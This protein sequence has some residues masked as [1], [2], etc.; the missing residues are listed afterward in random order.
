MPRSLSVLLS[1]VLLLSA[2][3]LPTPSLA[4]TAQTA[5]SAASAEEPVIVTAT[6]VAE[7][8]DAALEPVT[9][10]GTAE[11]ER[12]M[13]GDVGELLGTVIGADVARSGGPG[14]PSSLFLR[15]ANSNQTSVMIDGVRINP[16]TIGGAN[17]AD[18][19]PAAFERIE[20]VEG[21][22]S[23][24]YGS[25]AIG[26]VV[27]LITRHGGPSRVDGAFSFGRF[28]S[29]D[30][31]LAG[32]LAG[33]TGDLGVLLANQES[34]GYPAFAAD[35][36][37]RG[38]RNDTLLLHGDSKD[39]SLELGFRYYRNE[40]TSAYTLPSFN[41]DGS[42]SFP[43]V[44]ERFLNS[45]GSATAAVQVTEDW[46]TKAVLSR[47]VEDL[48]QDQL[49]PF[50]NP[51]EY[52]FDYTGRN[53]LDWQNDVKAGNETITFGGI[54]ARETTDSLS[55]GSCFN[56]AC[57]P[58]K[59]R[60]D[61]YYLQDQMQLGQDRLL[62]AIGETEH[63][64]FGHHLTWNAE[65]GLALAEHWLLVADAG[66][67]FHAPDSTDRFSI[68]GGNPA[69]APEQARN[70]ELGLRA[71]DGPQSLALAVFENRIDE[72][73]ECVPMPTSLNP[74]ACLN[75]NVGRARIRGVETNWSYASNGLAARAG[76]SYQDPIDEDT[77]LRLVR[78]SRVQFTGSLGE[79]LGSA[80]FG[81]DA[82]YVGSRSD[83]DY[84]TGAGVTL[85]GYALVD[86][87]ARYSISRDWSVELK[88][89]NA[90]DR[91]YQQVSDYNASPRSAMLGTRFRFR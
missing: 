77:G 59:T 12:S 43:P 33:S 87:H 20:V 14:Q 62:L 76:A 38:F 91:H 65:Y 71:H 48:R 73:I 52:D 79:A 31:M 41:L 67:A 30:S 84:F 36:R 10:I 6:R 69:L 57:T 42:I 37:D 64:T 49:N 50:G 5:P 34:T 86:L 8:L 23:T 90:L 2:L 26:G 83:F 68:Y 22:R 56:A 9:V 39:G 61:S 32:D 80:E 89:A 3:L 7:P 44:D 15:A 17:L 53:A 11:I 1:S 35:W 58:V 47:T 45:M 55:Y 4:Q 27:N 75:E 88:L 70:L 29:K 63:S 28:D 24:L 81:A 46:R 51:G 85:G 82:L 18:L 25:D 72:L 60:V 16:G 21:P 40:G 19:D 66:T 74:F 78:R 13:A 54:W